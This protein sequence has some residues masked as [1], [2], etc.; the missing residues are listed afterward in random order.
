MHAA[1]HI[2][3]YI[4]FSAAYICNTRWYNQTHTKKVKGTL[5]LSSLI[6][7]IYFFFLFFFCLV[8]SP[9]DSCGI[10]AAAAAPALMASLRCSRHRQNEPNNYRITKSSWKAH[11]KISLP[12]FLLTFS[13][14]KNNWIFHHHEMAIRRA[15]QK[16]GK[17]Q[18]GKCSLIIERA[19]KRR[20]RTCQESKRN[21]KR[22]CENS[23]IKAI[24]IHL[25]VHTY[26]SRDVSTA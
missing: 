26:S 19:N 15:K 5:F 16:D 4:L 11:H 3:V 25:I 21:E 9:A 6:L 2:T 17:I 18:G 23:R 1:G 24:G 20:R 14:G 8:L 10:W 7:V 13:K 22:L 12:P